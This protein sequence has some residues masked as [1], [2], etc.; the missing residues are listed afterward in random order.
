MA[1]LDGILI[2]AACLADQVAVG[3]L[4]RSAFGEPHGRDVVE[5]VLA[6]DRFGATRASL[7]ATV[8]DNVI[9][10]VQLSR[11]WIDARRELVEVLVLSPL[12]VL[13]EHHNCG[14]GSRLLAAALREAERQ[15]APAVF[16]EGDWHYYGPRG[17]TAGAEYGFVRPSERIPESAFQVSVLPR[18]QTWMSGQLIYPEA[19]WATDTV[20]LRDPQLSDVE[21]RL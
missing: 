19:F 17:F 1:S 20:G 7:V 3:A 4:L 2:R 21:A 5:M 11:G 16:L 13:P 15:R 10:H 9:G 12:S 18:H 6:L 8:E 14:V